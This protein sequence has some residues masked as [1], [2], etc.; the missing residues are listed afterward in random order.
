MI[1]NGDARRTSIRLV[2]DG[3]GNPD[4]FDFFIGS[5]A[6]TK[7]GCQREYVC[8]RTHNKILSWNNGVNLTVQGHEFNGNILNHVP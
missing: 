6:P 4:F 8:I 1:E 7:T 3:E 2:R 5:Q